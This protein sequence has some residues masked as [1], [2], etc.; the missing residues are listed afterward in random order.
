MQKNLVVVDLIRLL[1][2]L[3]VKQAQAVQTIL[4]EEVKPGCQVRHDILLQIF[5]W[6][7]LIDTES[8][9]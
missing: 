3:C 9:G 7:Q 2:A 1:E 6:V 4:I 5:I 8:K